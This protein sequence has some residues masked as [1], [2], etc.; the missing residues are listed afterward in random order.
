[1]KKHLITGMLSILVVILTLTLV[2][3]TLNADMEWKSAT[4]NFT[5]TFGENLE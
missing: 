1:M 3:L 2:P 4:E 5:S